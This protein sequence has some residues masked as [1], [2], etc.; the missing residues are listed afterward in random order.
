MWGYLNLKHEG[1]NFQRVHQLTRDLPGISQLKNLPVNAKFIAQQNP[2]LEL[3]EEWLLEILIFSMPDEYETELAIIKSSNAQ[4]TLRFVL[5]RLRDK[6]TSMQ[7][8][9]EQ[10]EALNIA[11]GRQACHDKMD[12]STCHAGCKEFAT[13]NEGRDWRKSHWGS[14]AVKRYKERNK[15]RDIISDDERKREEQVKVAKTR[16]YTARVDSSEDEASLSPYVQSCNQ[17]QVTL[18]S[19][20]PNTINRY[21]LSQPNLIHSQTSVS[22]ICQ[23]EQIIM[24]PLNL[25]GHVNVG[26]LINSGASRH[27]C[28]DKSMFIEMMSATEQIE[29]GNKEVMTALGKGDV[30]IPYDGV[31][32]QPSSIHLRDVLYIPKI[33]YLKHSQQRKYPNKP[34]KR[35]VSDADRMHCRL[36][37]PGETRSQSFSKM[38]D[39][40]DVQLKQFMCEACNLMKFTRKTLKNSSP[41]ATNKLECVDMDL[42]SEN[43]SKVVLGQ[44]VSLYKWIADLQSALVRR[45][46]I[47]H[48]FHDIHGIKAI[49]CPVTPVK[50]SFSNEAY[51]VAVSEYELE[52]QKF[53]E[54][55]IEARSIL[56]A[57]IER[58]ICPPNLMNMSAKKIYDHVLS[59]RE[60][61]ANTPWETS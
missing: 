19:S 29:A 33:A 50:D 17:N 3:P 30:R 48:V 15:E 43:D 56:A 35:L 2:K 25:Y 16:R 34:Q 54:G 5:F 31:S 37:H 39:D 36:G 45:R 28:N 55:E 44:G 8:P 27:I 4:L 10:L 46:C 42:I 14:K 7:A 52:L 13:T 26:W 12:P 61:G 18:F 9:I 22:P 57:R 11:K 53:Q 58:A 41:L 51:A 23:P 6:E 24:M 40:I 60:E 59:V 1:E 21:Q 32:G 47:G 20:I 49:V 38:V